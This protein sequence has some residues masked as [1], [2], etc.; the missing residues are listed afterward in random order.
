MTVL[1]DEGHPPAGDFAEASPEQWQAL[2]RDVLRRA[3]GDAAPYS[4]FPGLAPY[5]REA[6]AEEGSGAGWDVRQRHAAPDNSAVL[7]D[8]ENGV[9]SLWLAVGADGIPV[10][11]LDRVLHGVQLAR[12]PVILDAGAETASAAAE[13]MRRY[14]AQGVGRGVA[15]GNLGA[16]PLGHEARTGEVLGFGPAA[17]LARRCVEAYPGLRALTV[18]ALPHH[19]AGGSAAQELGCALA[20]GVTYLRELNRVGVSGRQALAQLEFRY[21]ATA[22]QFL[23]IAKLR[24]ARRLWSRVTESGGAPGPGQRQHAVTSTAMTTRT[25]RSART[26]RTADRD[27]WANLARTAVAALAAGVGGAESVTVRPVGDAPGLPDGFTRRIARDASAVLVGESHLSPGADPAGGSRYV[28]QLT[29][30]LAHAAWDFFQ[31]I[32]RAGGQAAAL[33]SGMVGEELAGTGAAREA[34]HRPR[35]A[36]H[37]QRVP[38]RVRGDGDA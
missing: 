7:N 17:Y 9:T 20:T 26:A 38:V 36:D 10:P 11:A 30:E 25:P 8:L 29:D 12:T 22:D 16:D 37:Q 4:G 24:A 2:V 3:P 15:R 14:D 32:E 28:E 5:L 21:A 19:E 34:P 6:R 1:P 13:L 33:R 27:R 18:D 35:G 31:R 23:T